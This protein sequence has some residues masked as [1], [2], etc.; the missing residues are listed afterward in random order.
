MKVGMKAVFTAI[1]LGSVTS[2]ATPA[3]GDSAKFNVSIE[4]N[5]AAITGS[6]EMN[7]VSV[8]ASGNFM[9]RSVVELEGQPANTSEESVATND[10]LADERINEIVANCAGF[11]GTAATTTIQS[12]DIPTCVLPLADDAGQQNGEIHIG[13]VPFGILKQVQTN[14]QVGRRTVLE[15]VSFTA[16]K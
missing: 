1:L 8:D 2:L 15:L 5:G 10:L 9:M 13:A 7:L 11:G 12:L 14:N 6:Y 3:V 4:Q 16:G